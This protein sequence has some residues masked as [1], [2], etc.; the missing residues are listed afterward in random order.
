MPEARRNGASASD[1]FIL[2]MFYCSIDNDTN[3]DFL[4]LCVPVYVLYSGFGKATRDPDLGNTGVWFP[5]HPV[6]SL[7][8]IVSIPFCNTGCEPFSC[9]FSP[10]RQRPVQETT[11]C[12]LCWCRETPA[13]AAFAFCSVGCFAHGRSLVC[14]LGMGHGPGG[15][16]VGALGPSGLLLPG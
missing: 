2:H 7:G 5:P 4:K 9:L 6:C 16:G 13:L 11:R 1:V 12:C 10:P 3:S 15:T 8:E 14:Q